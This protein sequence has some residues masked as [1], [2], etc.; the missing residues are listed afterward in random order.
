M[1]PD[2]NVPLWEIPKNKPQKARGYL[3]VISDNLQESLENPPAKYHGSTMLGAPTRPCPSLDI[4]LSL[5]AWGFFSFFIQ[6][7]ERKLSSEQ[8]LGLPPWKLT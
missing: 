6:E 4:A 8:N 1:Y 5:G 3:W 2:P 7:K